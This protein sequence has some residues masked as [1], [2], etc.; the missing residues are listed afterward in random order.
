[1]KRIIIKRDSYYDSVVLMRISAELKKITGVS[2][3]VVSMGTEVNINLLKQ[4]GFSRPELEA[5]TP[6][7]LIIAVDAIDEATTRTAV[8]SA[9]VLIGK[10]KDQIAEA[11]EYRPVSLDATVK[12]LPDANMVIIS[13]PGAYAAAEARKALERGLHVMLF[14]DNVSFED[15][16]ALKKLAV[17]KGLLMMGP[18]CGTAIISGKPLCFANVV[19]RGDIGI[20]GATG[21]GIQE[22][23]CN[24]DRFGGGISQAIGTGGRDLINDEVGGMMTLMGIEALRN[25]PDTRVI[26]VI[27]KP[28]APEVAWKV[29]SAL[30]ETE[31][32]CVIHFVGLESSHP[33]E[34]IW[35]AESLEMASAMAVSLSRGDTERHEFPSSV[36]PADLDRLAERET[37]GMRTDQ[38]YLRG[39]FVGGAL[40]DEAIA[41]FEEEAGDV[42]SNNQTKSYLL[43][44]DPHVSHKHTIVDLGDDAFTVGRPHPMIDPSIRLERILK[45]AEDPNLA[46]ILLDMVLGY[47]AHEDPVGA[48]LEGLKIAKEKSQERNGYLSIV[49][50]ITGTPEDFQDLR[51]QKAELRQIGAVVMPSNAQAAMLASRIIKRIWGLAVHA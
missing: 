26:V 15:E 41:I 19:R 20:V 5:V 31:K 1:M 10:K 47:G 38:R 2:E 11:G 48:I 17:Q 14:S 30:K 29:A 18:D 39:L 43:L 8:E 28:P 44:K 36:H 50:S 27:S 51:T 25:D 37:S 46:V 34:N 4:V 32:P 45:E 23:T 21:T 9:K 35:V 24:I 13:V 16:I 40:A 7:D 22:V 6:N 33:I 3:A 12:M 42:Y 49:A